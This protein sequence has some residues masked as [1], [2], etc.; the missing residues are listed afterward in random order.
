MPGAIFSARKSRRPQ[1]F[2]ESSGQG[3][4]GPS[5]L[6]EAFLPLLPGRVEAWTA[7]TEELRRSVKEGDF[8]VVL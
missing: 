2:R 3:G 8:D 6:V 7:N 4:G 1:K 5:Q